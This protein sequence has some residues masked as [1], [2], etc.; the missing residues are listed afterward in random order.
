MTR[1]LPCPA[2]PGALEG[3]AARFD[4]L[5]GSLAQR[6]GSREYLAGL[7]APRDRNKVPTALGRGGAKSG[8]SQLASVIMP[9]PMVALVASSIRMIPPVILLRA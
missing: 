9:A 2:T 5:F 7:L 8:Q 1:R 3:C 6:Q 4:E